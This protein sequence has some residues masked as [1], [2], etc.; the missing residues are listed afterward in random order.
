MSESNSVKD[1]LLII[2]SQI[3]MIIIETD[4][5]TK[6]I[7]I[8][9]K[10]SLEAK[11]PAFCWSITD[12]LVEMGRLVFEVSQPKFTDPEK[13]L[14][15]IDEN[16]RSGIYALLDF[17]PYLEDNPKIIRRLK[18]IAL[19]YQY[20]KHTIILVSHQMV[21]PDDLKKFSAKFEMPV[22]DT[23]A[24]EAIIKDEARQYFKTFKKK[25]SANHDVLKKLVMNLQGLNFTDARRLARKAIYDDGVISESDIPDVNRA[26]YELLDMEGLLY[27]E[28]ETAHFSDV[29]DLRNLKSWLKKRQIAFEQEDMKTCL[30]TPKGILL[31]GVQGAGKSL[32]AKSV[33]GA[34]GLPLLRL[35]FAV[36][37]N[38]YFGETERNLRKALMMAETVCPC[39]LWIDEIEKGI[40]SGDYDSGT[41]RRVMGTFLTWMAERKR[42][43]FIVATS[44]DIS[45]LPPELLRKGRLDEIFFVDL[46][47]HNARQDIF[48]I[49]LQKRDCSPEDFEIQTL[50]EAT[51]G[52]SGAE[53]EQAVVSARYLARSAGHFLKTEDI[54]EEIGKTR[55]LSVVMA[56]NISALRQWAAGRTVRAN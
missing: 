9:R 28:Y 41:S 52:F 48:S 56:E 47:D 19:R 3:P 6:V 20:L 50:A 11:R 8:V 18:E 32:A 7:D 21:L 36:L 17:H 54:L 51:D 44:N 46:P 26:K 55:P 23:D 24:L 33:A 37:Y 43:V 22:P 49:H 42:P 35:D 40:A 1:L 2:R 45:C 30:D 31:V 29:G 13:L 10:L 34:W 53:I 15:Q 25:V 4:E 14:M 39:V 27:F 12:G 16:H 5:E 38:K